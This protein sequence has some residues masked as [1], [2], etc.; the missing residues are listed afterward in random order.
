MNL[1]LRARLAIHSG[2]AA[3][4]LFAAVFTGFVFATR[5]ADL[6]VPQEVLEPA[7]IQAAAEL[8]QNPA[9]PDFTEITGAEKRLSIAAFTSSGQKISNSG[10]LQI[11]G[12]LPNGPQPIDGTTYVVAGKPTS[13]GYVVTAILWSKEG[14]ALKRLTAMLAGLWVALTACVVAATWFGSRATFDHLDSMAKR[15]GEMGGDDLSERLPVPQDQ[16]FAR[17]AS[18][19]NSLLDRIA[20]SVVQQERFVADAAHEL[21][22][23]LTILQMNVDSVLEKNRSESEYRDALATMRAETERLSSLV[24]MLLLSASTVSEDVPETNLATADEQAHARWVDQ[25]ESRN[26][27][28]KLQTE[29]LS[30]RITE[31]EIEVILNNLVANALNVSPEQATCLITVSDQGNQAQIAVEDQGPGVPDEM[32]DK[33]FDRLVKGEQSRNRAHG[34]FGIGL[35]VCRRI[36][37]ARHGAIE[38]DRTYKEGAR[39]V[40]RLPLS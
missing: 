24:E 35:A 34:G 33:I 40:I 10:Q 13:Q 1:G 12:I 5:K 28:L 14:A 15:A 39:F 20:S 17:F 19:L 25:F 27:A 26:V 3:A 7:V 2:S 36:V 38:L 29:D 11:P 37:T 31:Q 9:H 6:H 18:Q 22:T 4:L 8:Q 21:R 30:A 16:E 32:A 23:P